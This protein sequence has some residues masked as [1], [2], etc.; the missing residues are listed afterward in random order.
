MAHQYYTLG[1][2]GLINMKLNAQLVP[3]LSAYSMV[4]K[5]ASILCVL[6]IFP[7]FSRGTL[8]ST[9]AFVN[10]RSAQFY[11][12]LIKTLLLERSNCSI[13]SLLDN[14]ARVMTQNVA[15]VA[16]SPLTFQN[17]QHT[18]TKILE[19]EISLENHHTRPKK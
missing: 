16:K 15:F 3:F 8:K 6:V 11:F 14:I 4:G 18:T 5:D 10:K 19:G 13:P 7:S 12:Y 1:T 17:A 2:Y 9:L